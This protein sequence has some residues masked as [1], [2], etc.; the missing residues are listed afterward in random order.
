MS[1]PVVGS[2]QQD[3]SGPDISREIGRAEA[4][5]ASKAWPLT[6][7]DAANLKRA[8]LILCA[9]DVLWIAQAA[10]IALVSAWLLEVFLAAKLTDLP[11]DKNSI[12]YLIYAALGFCLLAYIR[13]WLQWVSSRYANDVAR[14]AK[15]RLRSSF[16]SSIAKASPAAKMAD[17][18]TI[19]VHLAEHVDALGPYLS[20][21]QPQMMRVKV[22]PLVILAAILPF[23]WLAAII[24]LV[25]G[26]IIP[27][28]MALIGIRAKAASSRQQEELARMGSVLLDRIRGLE[29]LRLFGALPRTVGEVA[30]AGDR[31][32]VGTMQVLKIA[33]LSSTV[34][35]LFS[36]L[37]I[38]FVAV[39]VGFSLLGDV[40]SGTWG[41][42]LSYFSGLFILL[43][44]P[45]FFAPLRSYAAAYH[46]RAAGLS[47]AE[48]LRGLME[49]LA[50]GAGDQGLD[51]GSDHPRLSLPIG[52]APEIEVRNLHVSHDDKLVL[53]DF[54]F[55]LASG[56]AL[57]ITG[58]SG[59]GKTTL[60][61]CLLGFLKVDQ[62]V[63]HI[64]GMDLGDLDAAKWRQS[65]AWLGQSPR[66]FHGSLQANLRMADQSADE[67]AMMKA[68]ELA[69]AGNLLARL[70]HGLKTQLGDDG[71]GLSVGEARR[72]ALARAALR[73]H[74]G[75]FIADEPT[76]GLDEETAN[77]VRAGL[78]HLKAGRTMLIVTHD[79]ALIE[80]A[81]QH[82]VLKKAGQ[83]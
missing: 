52:R 9:A 17:S 59:A 28:F 18:G 33:F 5:L 20:R 11:G 2:V 26:P 81:D 63:I 1:A 74:A 10:I 15:L 32:R 73:T 53:Q 45:E 12:F 62:G 78:R 49:G 14:E 83:A 8:G 3:D 6:G 79:P 31:F 22:V 21:F 44:V 58:E 55:S 42:P 60:L 40:S 29:T 82:L 4:D 72:V 34:L 38:A 70:P 50:G 19:S 69:G 25:C 7:D 43:L 57:V 65:L 71:F 64:D 36:A 80:L 76:A 77:D 27:V 54:S 37:G 24:L 35:E 56:K 41:A 39:Y 61:D 13:A 16:L 68:L 67:G 48:K 46:D 66:L 47:A 23:S 30:E 75:L 51:K